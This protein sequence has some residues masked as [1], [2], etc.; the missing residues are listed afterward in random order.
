MGASQL[1]PENKIRGQ[2]TISQLLPQ[3]KNHESPENVSKATMTAKS[4]H[5]GNIKGHHSTTNSSSSIS[6]TSEATAEAHSV[7]NATNPHSKKTLKPNVPGSSHCD[8]N[9][10]DKVK[11]DET[12]QKKK[13]E[14]IFFYF[15]D[16][17]TRTHHTI[18]ISNRN[19]RSETK[20]RSATLS[21]GPRLN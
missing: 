11:I 1:Y 16:P 21:R 17:T 8:T 3:P 12:D 2:Y 5:T 14:T 7:S 4:D 13:K 9:S 18:P 20:F 19:Q 10:G 15:R 6:T